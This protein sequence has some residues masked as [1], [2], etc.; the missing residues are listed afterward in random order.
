MPSRFA[1]VVPLIAPTALALMACGATD[2]ASTARVVTPPA[3]APTLSVVAP[4]LAPRSPPAPS[5]VPEL[6]AAPAPPASPDEPPT[7]AIHRVASRVRVTRIWPTPTAGGDRFIGLLRGRQSVALRSPEPVPGRGCPGPFYAIEPRGY[8]CNDGTLVIDADEQFD[9]TS[10]AFAEQAGPFPYRYAISNFAPMY[11]RIPTRDEQAR[12]EGGF[13]PPGTFPRL[14]KFLATHEEMATADPILPVDP[15]PPFLKDS[16]PFGAARFGLL[17]RTIPLGSMLSFTRAFEVDGRTWLL[18]ADE[19]FVPA[20]RV[21]A[22]R[23]SAFHGVH[24]GGE[25]R[26]P[27]AWLRARPRPRHRRLA[28]GSFEPTGES[29]PAR[30]YV[31]LTGVSAEAGRARYLE[32]REL[33]PDGGGPLWVAASDATVVEARNQLPMGVKADQKW[34][35]VSIGRGTMVAYDKLEPVYATLISPGRGGQPRKGHDPVQDSTTPTGV[36]SVT[37]KDRA[38]T[39]SP[40]TGDTRTFWIADVPYTQYFNPPFALHAAFWHEHFGEPM[41]A[42]CVNLAPID[43]KVMFDWSDPKLPEGW[44]G[45]TGAGAVRENGPTTAVVVVR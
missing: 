34:I 29:W 42:G 27:L 6:T 4:S 11:N 43:A 9:R 14:P 40:D 2:A 45:V 44:H 31:Q 7:P 38:S 23:P 8:I 15:I 35:L 30:G 41:S 3:P 16:A 12:F 21:R 26:L 20:D 33:A 25:V 17:K 10:E 39:M 28:T 24:L 36:Y 22:F 19:T 13:G 5:A 18:S 37:F 1:R 32:T